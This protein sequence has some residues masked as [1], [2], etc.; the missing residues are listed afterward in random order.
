ME[1]GATMHTNIS[2]PKSDCFKHDI[3]LRSV[4]ALCLVLVTIPFAVAWFGYYADQT[5]FKLTAVSRWLVVGLYMVLY[6]VFGRIYNAF[7][8]SYLRISDIIYGQTLSVLITDGFICIFLSILSQ[9]L[10]NMLLISATLAGQLALIAAWAYYAHRWYFQTFAAKRTVVV[11]DMREGMENLIHHYGLEKKFH[12]ERIAKVSECLEDLSMLEGMD[13]VFLSDIHSHERNV[14]IKYCVEHGIDALIIPRVGDILMSG[15]KEMHLFHLPILQVNRYKPT[16]EFLV[17]KRTFDIALSSFAL[18][19]LSPLMLIVGGLI[20]RDG[21]PA[22]Y[23]QK[24]LT[25]DGKVFDILKFRSMKVDAEKDGIARLSTGDN[26]DRITPIGRFIRKVRIDELP[27]LINILRGEMSI[28]G[29]RPERP[30]IAAQ[31]ERELPEFKLRLQAKAGLT[32]YAQVYGKYNTTPYDKLQLDLMYIAKPSIW[33]E[34][35][36]CFSTVKILFMQESTE[37]IAVGRM[38]AMSN[39]VEQD[40][41]NDAGTERNAQETEPLTRTGT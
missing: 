26:D 1:M 8:I 3:I 5:V 30:E 16:P 35:M 39:D 38:T 13:A 21:G 37:G 14:I 27:Q 9:H 2:T 23:R 20:R 12:V 31:Y 33:Q 29:P 15:A 17:F 18:L 25:K 28:V 41:G 10:P 40:W 7:L 22:L 11:Y 19:A 4:K 24:R 32:G 36:I 34:L 6:Y